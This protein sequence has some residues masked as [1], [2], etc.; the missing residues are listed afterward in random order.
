MKRYVSN[1]KANVSTRNFSE[2]VNDLR[3]KWRIKDDGDRYLFF[4]TTVDNH[5]VA[6]DC[7]KVTT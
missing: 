4:T 7:S 6:L 3:K 5:K 1:S 2:N